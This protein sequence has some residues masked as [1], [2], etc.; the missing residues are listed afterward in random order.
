MTLQV[1]HGE[2]YLEL[3]SPMNTEG[4]LTTKA[5][6]IDVQEKKSGAVITAEC[7]MNI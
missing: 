2:Q 4:S 3:V 1:L 7:N 6:V 5:S